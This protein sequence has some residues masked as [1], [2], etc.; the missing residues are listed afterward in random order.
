M[1]FE[2]EEKIFDDFLRTRGLKHSEQRRDILKTFLETEK[3][4]KADEL[5]ELVK[6]VNPSIGRST[7]YR[8]LKLFRESGLCRELKLDDGTSRYEHLYGHEHHDHLICKSCGNLHEV[9]DH[10]IE[11]LQEN[12][13]KK[14]GFMITSHKLVMY[15]ICSKC[16]N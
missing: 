16:G 3:H 14:H 1:A 8:T 4:L 7:V 5:D 11:R 13:A 9:Y 6:K 12:L 2:E 10:E 15:G